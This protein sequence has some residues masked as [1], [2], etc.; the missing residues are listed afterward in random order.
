[1]QLKIFYT[2]TRVTLAMAFHYHPTDCLSELGFYVLPTTRSNG[3]VTSV[4]SERPEK[5]EI[6]FPT[7]G[8][9]V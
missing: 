5:W 4:L 9:A 6:D 7:P 3:D 8:L 1:M 2:V